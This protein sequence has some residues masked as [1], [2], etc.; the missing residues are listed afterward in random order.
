MVGVAVAEPHPPVLAWSQTPPLPDGH[1]STQEYR[2]LLAVLLERDEWG[3][4]LTD[5]TRYRCGQFVAGLKGQAKRRLLVRYRKVPTAT[6]DRFDLWVRVLPRD[7]KET[8][9]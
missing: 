7:H 9:P 8:T 5:A 1:T 6:L 2:A 3:Q 4:V